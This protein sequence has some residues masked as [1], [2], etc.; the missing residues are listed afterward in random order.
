MKLTTAL[1]FA[2]MTL[3]AAAQQ[4]ISGL[5]FMVDWPSLVGQTVTIT[6]GRVF[7]A[8]ADGALLDVPGGSVPLRGPWADREDLR[9]LF[10][11]C[12]GIM[13]DKACEI[14]VTGTVAKEQ[15]GDGVNL[16]DTDFHTP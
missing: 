9:Y 16:T 5:D 4:Q 14:A 12:E 15:F 2:A 8:R 7:G 3:P 10:T 1:V 6:D 13:P 11:H